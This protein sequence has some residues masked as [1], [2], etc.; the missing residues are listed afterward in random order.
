MDNSYIRIRRWEKK[1]Y[2]N[3]I[4]QK[5]SKRILQAIEQLLKTLDDFLQFVEEKLDMK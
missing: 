1:L 5:I 3:K 4:Q 2:V